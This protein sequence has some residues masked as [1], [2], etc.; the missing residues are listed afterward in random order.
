MPVSQPGSG[1]LMT[2]YRVLE[3]VGDYRSKHV[4]QMAYDLLI[5][6][7]EILKDEELRRSFLVNI[8]S[9]SQICALVDSGA[10][11]G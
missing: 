1:I 6:Q 5:Q 7:A 2:C 4:L 9:N 8:H 3:M 10:L 11:D